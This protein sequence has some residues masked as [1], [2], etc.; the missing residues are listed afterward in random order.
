MSYVIN[1]KNMKKQ[2]KKKRK[3]I[4]D[5]SIIIAVIILLLIIAFSTNVV[6]IQEISE[7]VRRQLYGDPI[8]LETGLINNEY[9]GINQ[10]SKITAII[11]PKIVVNNKNLVLFSIINICLNNTPIPTKIKVH[12]CI[13]NIKSAFSY[14]SPYKTFI[15]IG[16]TILIIIQII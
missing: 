6:N 1:S 7:N 16:D 4:I 10:K 9:F 3:R 14:L 5:Y 11:V 13:I 8:D 15:I 12:I 2:M